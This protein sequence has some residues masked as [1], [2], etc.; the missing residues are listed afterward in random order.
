LYGTLRN[1]LGPHHHP[2]GEL[3]AV[4]PSMFE[5]KWISPV[6]QAVL[7]WA[8]GRSTPLEWSDRYSLIGFG[9]LGRIT[10][11]ETAPDLT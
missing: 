11:H 9:G 4:A 2:E 10:L 6:A 3:A 7:D 1:L 8:N 5:P